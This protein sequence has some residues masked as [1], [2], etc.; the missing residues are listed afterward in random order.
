M[1]DEVRECEVLVVG[2]GY[3]GL[4]AARHL[5]SHGVDVVLVEARDRVGGRVWTETT[6]SGAV[7]DHGGQWVGPGQDNLLALAEEFEVATFPTYTTGEGVEIRQGV[8][9]TYAG[10]IPTSD[11]A[12]AAE[13]IEA[14]FELDLASQEV[15][16]E[17]PWN[18]PEAAAQD[19]Q[20]LG[21]WLTAH[22]Q[23]VPARS[24][25]D[26]AVK[27]VFGTEAGEMSLLY[28]L[29]YLHAGG[30][31][32]NLARTTGGA[33]ERRFTGGAQQFALRMAEEL[34][35]RIVLSS[36]VESID[37]GD[38]SVSATL[39]S[40][41][42]PST[43]QARRVVVAMPPALAG[44]LRWS[45]ALPALRDQLSMR[46]PMG[47]VSK[48]HAVYERPFWRDQGLNGQ[49]VADDGA[50]RVTFDDSPPDGSL[51][52]LVGFVAGHECRQFEGLS[53][54]ERH[55][56]VLDD[57]MRAFGPEAGAPVEL[58]EQRW[59]DEPYTRGGPVAVFTPG[60]LTGCGV[61]LRQP[62]GPIH[63]A[64]TE[65]AVEW[66]GYIDGALSSGLRAAGEVLAALGR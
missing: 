33:Q 41:D 44:R 26:A 51:G 52:I 43:V 24:M 23:S 38:D 42:G 56:V 7:V 63:W 17:A 58:H 16:L 4:S 21:S 1:T 61:A 36:P 5:A 28:A 53:E 20:T 65:T 40:P 12:A 48:Y 15:P 11:P 35:D 13:G 10:L 14:I 6:S 30:G 66:C 19:E 62:V 31:L 39:S 34:G 57:L 64:G 46:A 37:Y 49:L 3:A 25:I 29:F 47:A 32:M 60:L 9:R 27:A 50:L 55:K 18:A 22:V 54:E 8:R 45:P 59:C 2:A